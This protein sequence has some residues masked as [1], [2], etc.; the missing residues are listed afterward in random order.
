MFS[1]G[2]ENHLP[3]LFCYYLIRMQTEVIQ[4]E[5]DLHCECLLQAG[6]NSRKGSINAAEFPIQNT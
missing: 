1:S 3:S 4:L 2:L 5:A 6:L